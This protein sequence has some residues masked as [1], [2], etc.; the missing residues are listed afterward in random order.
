MFFRQLFDHDSS[1]YTYLLADERTRE[2]VIIDAD[3]VSAGG[4]AA[5]GDGGLEGAGDEGGV[6]GGGG[7][8]PAG[9]GAAGD[10]DAHAH[11]YEYEYAGRDWL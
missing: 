11:G 1:T 3:G 4:F 5:R 8:E 6:W 10:E 9:V 2:A 7:S